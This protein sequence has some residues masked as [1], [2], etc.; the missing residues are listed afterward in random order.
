VA[1]AAAEG[2][3]FRIYH[4]RY[5]EGGPPETF[6]ASSLERGSV[7]RTSTLGLSGDRSGAAIV[8]AVATAEDHQS[9]SY[10]E[11]TFD[12]SGKAAA[13]KVISLG[14]AP[15]T[16]VQAA[17]VFPAA[18][19]PVVVVQLKSGRLL[20]MAENR[21]IDVAAPGPATTPL[22]LAP[23]KQTTYMLYNGSGRGLYLD[24]M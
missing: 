3:G 20:K 8:G 21:L 4:A 12:P 14:K 2:T 23:G 10:V 19:R 24:R 18:N 17:V 16:V 9:V 15:E 6:Q 22:L 13:P 1:F 11:V 7:L 5:K